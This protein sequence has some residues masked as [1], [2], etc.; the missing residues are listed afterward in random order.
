MNVYSPTLQTSN[1][2]LEYTDLEKLYQ[3]GKCIVLRGKQVKDELPVILKVPLKPGAKAERIRYEFEI[4]HQIH[5][6]F[7][8]KFIEL[9][10]DVEHGYVLIEDDDQAESLANFI[11]STGY[12]PLAFLRIAIQ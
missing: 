5:S 10:A 8:V 11:P 4:G 7:V 12:E 3:S 2:L 6:D 1:I 9:R